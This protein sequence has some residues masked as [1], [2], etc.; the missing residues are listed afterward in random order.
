MTDYELLKYIT[1]GRH[2]PHVID[3]SVLERAENLNFKRNERM[4]RPEENSA[5]DAIRG[6]YE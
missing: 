2:Y 3:K 6:E 1:D 5:F 4:H